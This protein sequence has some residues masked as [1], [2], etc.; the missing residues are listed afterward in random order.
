MLAVEKA[1][2]T[3]ET[4]CSPCPETGAPRLALEVSARTAAGASSRVLLDVRG[5]NNCRHKALLEQSSEI[6]TL[7][8]LTSMTGDSHCKGVTH[9]KHQGDQH[10]QYL[11]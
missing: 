7:M 5:V 4:A 10:V 6:A 8:L 9:S 2:L 1:R 3:V 11:Q